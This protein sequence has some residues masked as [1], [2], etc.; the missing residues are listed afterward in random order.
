MGDKRRRRRANSKGKSASK[1]YPLWSGRKDL[2]MPSWRRD[3]DERK[4][5]ENWNG[6]SARDKS[7]KSNYPPTK[8][9]REKSLIARQ[10]IGG[11]IRADKKWN[12]KRNDGL[13]R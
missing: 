13:S 8:S 4:E 5:S 9:N 7:I 10:G 12:E 3:S 6:F 11:I 2:K 1:P